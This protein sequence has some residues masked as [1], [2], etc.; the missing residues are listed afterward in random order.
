MAVPGAPATI[1]S[2][3]IATAAPRRSLRRPVEVV[4]EAVW[5]RV[6]GPVRANV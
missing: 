6:A 3:S 4:N 2:P 1:V 5:V